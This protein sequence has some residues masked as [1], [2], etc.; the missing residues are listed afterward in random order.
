MLLSDINNTI[1][2]T[3]STMT[4]TRW[5]LPKD[6]EFVSI[7]FLICVI[8]IYIVSLLENTHID[9]YLRRESQWFK[10]GLG[11]VKTRMLV[12]VIVMIYILA[13]SYPTLWISRWK[14]HDAPHWPTFWV[15]LLVLG[16]ISVLSFGSLL[17]HKKIYV[18]R[19]HYQQA[20]DKCTGQ[21]QKYKKKQF[22]HSYQDVNKY[23][24]G[25]VENDEKKNGK[26]GVVAYS[27]YI[28]I[29]NENQMRGLGIN[30][31]KSIFGE[32]YDPN[33]QDS[34]YKYDSKKT[35]NNCLVELSKGEICF[36]CCPIFE[37]RTRI[38]H[39][40]IEF[41]IPLF[42]T[43]MGLYVNKNYSDTF[44]NL[45][46]VTNFSSFIEKINTLPRIQFL[47]IKDEFSDSFRFKNNFVKCNQPVWG[48]IDP[49]LS[50]L[51]HI[52]KQNK[53]DNILM[54]VM[55]VGKFNQIIRDH[56]DKMITDVINIFPRN[57]IDYPVS[58]AVNKTELTL[59]NRLNK[60]ILKLRETQIPVLEITGAE[61]LKK[62]SLYIENDNHQIVAIDSG[63]FNKEGSFYIRCLNSKSTR[64]VKINFHKRIATLEDK[65]KINLKNSSIPK[66]KKMILEATYQDMSYF[67]EADN[68]TYKDDT[69]AI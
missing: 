14:I 5:L 13:T 52:N 27:P 39:F 1:I 7:I 42:F 57:L 59:K 64:A 29:I 50:M 21:I 38:Y 16:I 62:Y 28:E 65:T 34:R 11:L 19:L 36:L 68:Y 22:F 58:F 17:L 41:T 60:G 9:D 15:T 46:N 49:H 20:F 48:K 30:I 4:V 25:I 23:F 53:T 32:G 67:P 33:A 66:L 18:S 63:D 2:E 47:Y 43:Q 12:S 44:K 51:E 69:S 31:L 61:F 40:D 26:I 45:K 10:G 54:T 8:I 35:W 55:E 24:N 56:P 37:T 6:M 3:D